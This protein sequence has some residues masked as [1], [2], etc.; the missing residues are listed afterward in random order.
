MSLCE[1]CNTKTLFKKAYRGNFCIISNSPKKI[2]E[3]P[4]QICLLKSMCE[5]ECEE[6][7]KLTESIFKKK[8]SYDYKSF[9]RDGASYYPPRHKRK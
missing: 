4:C 1:G 8:L 3:C 7:K 9:Y 5:T 6:F 2:P